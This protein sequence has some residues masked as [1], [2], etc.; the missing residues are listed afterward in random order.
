MTHAFAAEP[1]HREI[2]VIEPRRDICAPCAPLPGPYDRDDH[3][4]GWAYF[5]GVL[6]GRAS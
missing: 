2:N 3:E 6:T 1:D 5:L 4:Q